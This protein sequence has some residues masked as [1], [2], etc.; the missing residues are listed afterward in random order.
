M[1]KC[2]LALV[3]G[4][5]LATQALQADVAQEK[6][7]KDY[8][9]AIN[10][11]ESTDLH[12]HY[13]IKGEQKPNNGHM[14]LLIDPKLEINKII[15][16]AY[17]KEFE[18]SLMVQISSLFERKGYSVSHVKSESEI[19]EEMKKKA[20]LAL[21]VE[22]SMAILEDIVEESKD[23]TEERVIDMSS[24]Y[25]NLNLFEPK[26]GDIIHSFGVD[27]SKIKAVIEHIMLTRTNSGGYMPKT[28]THKVKETDHDR[29]IRKIMNQ[30]YQ[31][32]MG[33]V[34]KELSLKNVMHYQQVA[35]EIKKRK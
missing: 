34:S 32:T 5:L 17:Q 30:A 21:R 4:M 11:G 29:A 24:G 16:Q 19:S 18:K 27:I 9:H 3:V 8:H 15:P 23:I 7:Q 13:P 28:V 1:K 2:N 14:V 6:A 25:V 20:R 22:G 12:F 26:S 31:K 33:H 35:S 10:T